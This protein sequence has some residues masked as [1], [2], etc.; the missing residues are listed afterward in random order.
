MSAKVLKELT[1]ETING[2]DIELHVT[3]VRSRG[4]TADKSQLDH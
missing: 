3:T 2:Y 4:H 1:P